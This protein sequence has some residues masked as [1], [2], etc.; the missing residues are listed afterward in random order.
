MTK[1]NILKIII[2][3]IIVNAIFVYVSYLTYGKF[4]LS[5]LHIFFGLLP[6]VLIIRR[7]KSKFQS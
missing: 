1:Q 3:T 4:K 6:L 2:V 7:S 5:F